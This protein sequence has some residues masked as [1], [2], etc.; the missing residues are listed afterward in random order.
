MGN[1]FLTWHRGI[2]DLSCAAGF[3]CD[4]TVRKVICS[5]TVPLSLWALHEER[6]ARTHTGTIRPAEGF[7]RGRIYRDGHMILKRDATSAF[8]DLR[9]L[10]ERE[11][12][13]A[14]HEHRDCGDYVTLPRLSPDAGKPPL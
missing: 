5:R 9:Q 13:P 7:S 6:S 1:S 12:I 2:L 8:L 4:A 10:L 11:I 3:G 14:L